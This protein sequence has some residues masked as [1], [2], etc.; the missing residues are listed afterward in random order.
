MLRSVVL[1]GGLGSSCWVLQSVNSP[2]TVTFLVPCVGTASTVLVYY[3]AVHVQGCGKGTCA[4]F[5]MFQSRTSSH[6]GGLNER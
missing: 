6:R 2:A 4:S 1:I 5:S 3:I